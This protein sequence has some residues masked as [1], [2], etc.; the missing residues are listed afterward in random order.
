MDSERY[1]RN[2]LLKEIG[3]DGQRR[4]CGSSV[5]VVGCG[6]TGGACAEMLVRAG[7][8][9]ITIMD[10]D[11]VDITNL[12]R[13]T[14]FTEND[15]GVEKAVS[16]ARMLKKMN[17]VV[18]INAIVDE[19]DAD[20]CEELIGSVDL[21]MD[22]TDNMPT[23]F[24]I[25]DACVKLGKPWIYMGAISTYGMVAPFV[26]GGACFRCLFPVVPKGLE[27]CD[28]AGVL[29]TLPGTIARMG[30]TEAMKIL[31]GNQ[32]ESDLI[33]YDGWAQHLERIAIRKKAD[34]KCCSRHDF[35]F[36][37]AKAAEVTGLCGGVFQINPECNPKESLDEIAA[38]LK[39]H[40]DVRLSDSAVVF[41]SG[42]CELTIF[43][44]GRT[45]VSGARDEKEAKSLYERY[46]R[47]MTA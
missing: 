22:C 24:I 23:R 30:A 19:L 9:H 29:N 35:E 13:Q 33:S 27:T 1:S 11:L 44:S 17:S 41:H 7:V 12:Q 3:E 20:N 25:N 32:M 14:L 43:D 16:A 36:L 6:G 38:R 26:P 37:E 46:V 40:G 47:G 31:L 39:G 8:G 5:F 4:L 45:L 15:V 34:C 2:I 21:V 42:G 18:R 28:A 10:R